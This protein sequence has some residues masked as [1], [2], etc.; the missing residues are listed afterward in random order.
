MGTDIAMEG[1]I[2][3][4]K[5]DKYMVNWTVNTDMPQLQIHWEWKDQRLGCTPESR[6][7]V[8]NEKQFVI[9]AYEKFQPFLWSQTL[10]KRLEVDPGQQVGIPCTGDLLDFEEK[11]KLPVWTK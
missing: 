8:V 9:R 4:E 10:Q 7:T 3:G 2:L 11:N 5:P 6:K 1:W